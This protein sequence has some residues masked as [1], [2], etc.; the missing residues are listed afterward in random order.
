MIHLYNKRK[1]KKPFFSIITV[2]KNDEK[3]ILKTLNSVKR[4]TSKNFEYII[5]DGDSNDKTLGILKRNKI[6]NILISEKDNGIYDAMNKGLKVSNGQV[7]LFVNSGD[8]ITKNALKIVHKIFVNN[9]DISFLF[10]TVLRHYK[11]S[12]IIKYGYN[13]N[14]MIYNFDF[15]TSHSTGFFLKKKIYKKI[16]LYNTK[17]KCSADYDIYFRL[18]K[19]KLKGAYTEKKDLISK[20]AAGGFSSKLS[21]FDHLMEETKIRINNKQNIL[22]ILLIIINACLKNLL[23][24]IKNFIIAKGLF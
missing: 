1:T 3:N 10:G 20:V 17:F 7:I 24:L 18:F 22:L 6:F 13:F 12:S 15:A 2:V 23:K 14:R 4:Q 19:M 11:T 5:I 8:I 21:F 16:G 9:E